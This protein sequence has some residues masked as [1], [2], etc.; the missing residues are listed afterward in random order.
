LD[1]FV[2]AQDPAVKNHDHSFAANGGSPRMIAQTKTA[3]LTTS[4]TA[5][6]QLT[7]GTITIPT[8]QTGYLKATFSGESLCTGAS[9]C[10][11]RVRVD[12]VEMHPQVGTDFAFDSPSDS[13]EAHSIQRISNLLGPGIHNVEVQ[14]AVVGATTF[15]IDDWLFQVEYWRVS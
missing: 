1:V 10:T 9:W 12:G 15:R 14:W 13:Y 11:L 2:A 5:Y 4:S 6:A 3:A 8:G 7:A